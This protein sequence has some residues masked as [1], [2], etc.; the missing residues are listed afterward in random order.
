MVSSRNFFQMGFFQLLSLADKLDG[1]RDSSQSSKSTFLGRF[2]THI[3]SCPHLVTDHTSEMISTRDAMA[4]MHQASVACC[5][6]PA[7]VHSHSDLMATRMGRRTRAVVLA[8]CAEDGP[9]NGAESEASSRWTST[10]S[11]RT[12]RCCVWATN[13]LAYHT[14]TDSW[15]PTFPS[16]AARPRHFAGSQ[17]QRGHLPLLPLC[18][19]RAGTLGGSGAR[20]RVPAFFARVST[21]PGDRDDLIG[22]GPPLPPRSPGYR[23][24]RVVLQLTYTVIFDVLPDPF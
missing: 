20:Q 9:N 18:P 11:S 17:C 8:T 12:T 10:A 13:A 14:L 15:H 4:S 6:C 2:A 7:T 19:L 16:P 5:F 1:R 23:L 22:R 21:Y 3:S 24:G